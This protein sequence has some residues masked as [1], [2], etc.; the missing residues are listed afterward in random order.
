MRR[1]A[2]NNSRAVD[3]AIDGGMT[4]IDSQFLVDLSAFLSGVYQDFLNALPIMWT[5]LK[6]LISPAAVFWFVLGIL[7]LPLLQK[8]R[9]RTRFLIIQFRLTVKSKGWPFRL[10]SAAMLTFARA[11]PRAPIEM[12]K[13]EIA[14]VLNVLTLIVELAK[15]QPTKDWKGLWRDVDTIWLRHF[16]S[17]C[18]TFR[19]PQL[20]VALARALMYE[21]L[22]PGRFDHRHLD[23]LA[24][25]SIEQW[26]TFTS[27]CSFACSI[28][29]RMTPIIFNFQD[30]I[31]DEPGL[32]PEALD[33]VKSFGLV[34]Q[35]GTGDAYTLSMPPEGLTAT[36]FDEEEFIVRPLSGPIPRNN[37][38]RTLI[39]SHH[40]DN[41]LNVGMVDFTQIGQEIGFLT[42]CS[43]VEGFTEYLKCRW[44]EYPSDDSNAGDAVAT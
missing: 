35:G 5:W 34:T 15:R 7:T 6:S 32:N 36:Y 44:R 4:L 26:K 21:A 38:G 22:N 17:R 8:A 20:Q 41:N 31:Y 12:N 40:F 18:G 28:S 9:I 42:A 43:K 10:I 29:G 1:Q 30:T 27:I 23:I 2:A 37:F 3:L 19:E 24:D 33:N 39:E 13:R 25:I 11:C 14:N 16:F